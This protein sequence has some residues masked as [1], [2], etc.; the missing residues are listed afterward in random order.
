MVGETVTRLACRVVVS[1]VPAGVA[2]PRPRKRAVP[3]AAGSLRVEDPL[4][5]RLGVDRHQREKQERDAEPRPQLV[6]GGTDRDHDREKDRQRQRDLR[7][8]QHRL[9]LRL[10]RGSVNADGDGLLVTATRRHLVGESHAP[11]ELAGISAEHPLRTEHTHDHPWIRARTDGEAG[12][13]E[14]IQCGRL[15]LRGRFSHTR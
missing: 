12:D 10:A 4:P 15:L 9:S 2:M 11:A 8:H 5:R 3:F 1:R 7:T 13:G 6:D 14:R